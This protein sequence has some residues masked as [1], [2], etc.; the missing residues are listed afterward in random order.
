MRTENELFDLLI[1]YNIHNEYLFVDAENSQ[2]RVIIY[3]EQPKWY[4]FKYKRRLSKFIKG[5]DDYLIAGIY[6]IIAYGRGLQ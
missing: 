1:E 3:F 4:Q 2:G 6:Y 5:V